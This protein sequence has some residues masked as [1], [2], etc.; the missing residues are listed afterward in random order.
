MW[1]ERV[2]SRL[3]PQICMTLSRKSIKFPKLPKNLFFVVPE[4]FSKTFVPYYWPLAYKEKLSNFQSFKK[5]YFFWYP[6]TFPKHRKCTIGISLMAIDCRIFKALQQKVWVLKFFSNI[7][8]PTDISVLRKD[9]QIF[10]AYQKNCFFGTRKIFKTDWNCPIGISLYRERLSNFQS[11]PKKS[12]W[13]KIVF[14]RPWLS[15]G[16]SKWN[17]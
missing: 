11:F 9:C 10:K 15:Y 3:D 13:P 17:C 2:V 16:L 14:Y 8:T 4:K 7:G 12:V 5:K 1:T 6:K